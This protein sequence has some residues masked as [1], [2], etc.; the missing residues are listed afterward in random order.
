V[1]SLLCNIAHT[2]RADNAREVERPSKRPY[3]EPAIDH[4]SRQKHL[5]R[6]PT[7]WCFLVRGFWS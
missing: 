6:G 3:T 1:D 4:G 7:V 5:V 2:G